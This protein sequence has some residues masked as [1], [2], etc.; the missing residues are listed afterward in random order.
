MP[1]ALQGRWRMI[2]NFIT[3]VVFIAIV[4]SG[5]GQAD[6]IQACG[7]DMDCLLRLHYSHRV[8]DVKYWA[9][10]RALPIDKR[11][12]AAPAQLVDY[13]NLENRIQ[14]FPNRPRI[15]KP[16][17]QFL[18]DINAA[19]SEIPA[20]VKILINGRLMGVFLV[21]DLGGT[22]FTDYVFDEQHEPVGAFVVLDAGVLTQSANAWATWKE[23]TPF[24][25][26]PEFN[27]Q[28]SIESAADDSRKQALQY[29]LLHEFGHVASVGRDFHPRWDEWDCKKNPPHQYPFLQ[30]SW[31]LDDSA[32]CKVISRFD[33]SGFSHRADVVFYFGAKLAQA[34]SPEVYTQLEQTDFPSLYAA[35]IPAED[36]AE[37][38]VTYVHQILMGKPFAIQIDKQGQRLTD[39]RGCWG[40][41]RCAAKQEMM[42]RLFSN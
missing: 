40:A 38:F 26:D 27:L 30:L 6:L 20:P 39:F 19:I 17:R 4:W 5:T 35:T 3:A 23:N 18:E 37:S 28:A 12:L 10:F 14:G 24:M 7:E 16:D 42:A 1:Q 13:L 41:A 36:F 22:G 8:K 15:A 31:R 25:P 34:V 29:I 33:Q 9:A 11:I 21:E 2:R 32:D